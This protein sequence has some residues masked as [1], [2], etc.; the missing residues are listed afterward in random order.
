MSA[1]LSKYSFFQDDLAVF[2]YLYQYLASLIIASWLAIKK[3]TFMSFKAEHSNSF[4]VQ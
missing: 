4:H 2:N 1:D 3:S